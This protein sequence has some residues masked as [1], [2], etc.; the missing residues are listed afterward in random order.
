MKQYIVLTIIGILLLGITENSNAWDSTAS[1][2]Y[3]LT[4]GNTWSYRHNNFAQF[5]C[6]PYT[7]YN[8]IVSI[9]SL[10]NRPNGKRYYKFSNGVL[11]RIDSASM[12]VYTYNGT[13]ECLFDSLLSRKNDTMRICSFNTSFIND[14]SMVTFQGVPRKTKKNQ[15]YIIGDFHH[16]LMYGIGFYYE[17]ACE[18]GGYNRTLNGAII[19]GVQFGAILGLNSGNEIIPENVSLSQNY[20]NPFNPTTHFGFRVAKFGLVRLSV[21]DVLG[22]EIQ[23]LVNEELKPGSYEFEW[24]AVDYPSGVYYY[25]LKVE[26]SQG[27]VFTDTKKMVLIK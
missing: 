18:G 2:Y 7:Y 3:P 11:R 26:T 12:N 4:V 13:G 6:F 23:L 9:D 17:I 25:K 15:K 10:V 14:T 24:D 1:K 8:F 20:P 27:D 5:S 22:K 21:Y 16:I 19:N